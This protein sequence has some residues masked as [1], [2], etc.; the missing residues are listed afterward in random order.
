MNTPTANSNTS[1]MAIDKPVPELDPNLDDNIIELLTKPQ[2]YS[3]FRN[4]DGQYFTSNICDDCQNT[5]L[6]MRDPTSEYYIN[7]SD[8]H[9]WKFNADCPGCVFRVH[10][11]AYATGRLDAHDTLYPDCRR[12]VVGLYD[13]ENTLGRH[14]TLIAS[15]TP[16]ENPDPKLIYGRRLLDTV[17][18]PQLKAWVDNCRNNHRICGLI[19][20]PSL[21]SHF[22]LIDCQTRTLV[23]FGAEEETD[24]VTL[25]YLWGKPKEHESEKEAQLPA[26][27][28]VWQSENSL[29]VALPKVI[30]DSMTVVL[31]LGYRYLWVDRYCI[32]QGGDSDSIQVRAEMIARMGS[33]YAGSAFTIIDA[34]GDG[35]EH[36]LA[37]V[38]AGTRSVQ[39]AI[40]L[41]D[42]RFIVG[43]G[44]PGENIRLSTWQTRGW[45][46]QEAVL[47]RRRLAFT[48]GQAYFQCHEMQCT[49]S[50]S[51]NVP[52]DLGIVTGAVYPPYQHDG[53]DDYDRDDLYEPWV[54]MQ[55]REAFGYIQRYAGRK[56]TYS[57][58]AHDAF[59][60]IIELFKFQNPPL[61]FL[62]G[63]TIICPAPKDN[64]SYPPRRNSENQDGVVG[65]SEEMEELAFALS[66]HFEFDPVT[67]I[68]YEPPSMVR[69]IQFPSWTW[70]GWEDCPTDHVFHLFKDT[71]QYKFAALI[72]KSYYLQSAEIRY[73]DGT[74][75]PWDVDW[76]QICAMSETERLKHSKLTAGLFHI[77]AQL[78]RFQITWRPT[79]ETSLATRKPLSSHVCCWL[80]TT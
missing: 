30:Q 14:K 55:M 62:Q 4:A 60:G 67:A 40:A 1:E 11:A 74:T 26:S 39:P 56:F 45:T 10:A 80:L 35:P 57:G 44:T 34:A 66:W 29:P 50:L 79:R 75:V 73:A 36:G 72:A 19:E 49:E 25:S 78:E 28:S 12:S 41:D 42:N 70:L 43:I 22:R 33:I 3:R 52:F 16:P 58:D 71:T 5:F 24:F 8:G 61:Y 21:T 47:S 64:V 77:R 7:R 20:R 65:P 68:H 38:S 63:L 37:G 53:Q 76:R 54:T 18:F 6:W 48:H 69:R 9:E 31:E 13:F 2:S 23:S 15:I 59:H 17:D 32:P 51:A 27:F 46:F